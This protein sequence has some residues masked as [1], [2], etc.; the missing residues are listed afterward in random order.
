[1][2]APRPRLDRRL[3]LGD[4]GQA[5]LA[6]RQLFGHRHPVRHVRHVGRFRQHHQ[7]RNLGLQL[8]LDPAGMLPG[9]RAVPAGVGM[10][11]GPIQRHRAQLQHPGLARQQQNLDEQ[12][13]DP[14]Q[15]APPEGRDRV[16]VRM[17]V[18]GDEPE[19]H[20]IVGRPLQLA[21]RTHPRRIAID[22]QAQQ[23][24]RVI[25]GRTRAAIRLDHRRQV[26]LLDNLDHEARQMPLRQPLVN[27]GRQKKP[28]LPIHRTEIAHLGH[29]P[30]ARKQP[31]IKN[32]IPTIGSSPTGC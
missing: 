29:H 15:K 4:A 12:G 9:Q 6:P 31:M 13:L 3:G 19:G 17:V 11:L 30:K 28:R 23:H 8:R 26:Q 18:G 2:A 24:A 7:F 16:M 21:A 25:R 32:S 22:Q 5:R 20:R 1:M 14:P 27:R 10:H